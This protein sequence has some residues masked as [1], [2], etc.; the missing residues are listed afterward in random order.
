MKVEAAGKE[1]GKLTKF[2]IYDLR[3]TQALKYLT[4]AEPYSKSYL[5]NYLSTEIGFRLLQ[6]QTTNTIVI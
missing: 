2:R 3:F 1:I 6:R 5:T 4:F